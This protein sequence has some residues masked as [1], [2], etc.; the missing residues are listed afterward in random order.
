MAKFAIEPHFR[1]QDGSLKRK[2]TS[3][4]RGS[5]TSSASQSV[6]SLAEPR[7]AGLP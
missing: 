1:L 6:V 4:R 3:R 2:A 7:D 5:I